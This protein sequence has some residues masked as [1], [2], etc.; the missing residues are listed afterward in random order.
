MP[1]TTG[2]EPRLK[3]TN[4]PSQP[5]TKARTVSFSSAPVMVR[6]RDIRPFGMIMEAAIFW[7]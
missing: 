6:W 3:G 4:P 7:L 2:R 1:L 5:S